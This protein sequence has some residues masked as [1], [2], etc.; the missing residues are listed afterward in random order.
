MD[1]YQHKIFC[2]S[3]VKQMTHAGMAFTKLIIIVLLIIINN[4]LS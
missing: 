3:F 4:K 1:Y 2:C